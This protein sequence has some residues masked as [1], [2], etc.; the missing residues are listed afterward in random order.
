[1]AQ[2]SPRSVDN[3]RDLEHYDGRLKNYP[4][5]VFPRQ[6]LALLLGAMLLA[7]DQIT[8]GAPVGQKGCKK[9]LVRVAEGA[10]IEHSPDPADGPRWVRWHVT[11]V[12]PLC[13]CRCERLE[14]L[15]TGVTDP[16]H[17]RDILRIPQLLLGVPPSSVHIRKRRSER[18]PIEKVMDLLFNDCDG[19]TRAALHF[20][21]VPA[22]LRGDVIERI[23]A[24]AEATPQKHVVGQGVQVAPPHQRALPEEWV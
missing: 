21:V 2:T 8:N 17:L 15:A 12:E 1:M 6:W 20:G 7:L 13:E 22:P 24:G 5:S 19:L 4:S 3:P 10:R 9:G 18:V 14:S 16:G 23:A 11:H